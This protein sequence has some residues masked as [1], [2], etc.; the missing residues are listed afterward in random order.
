MRTISKLVLIDCSDV[1][2]S[3]MKSFANSRGLD[4]VCYTSVSE[5][6]SISRFADFDV[7]IVENDKGTLSGTEVGEYLSAPLSD[8]PL[9]IISNGFRPSLAARGAWPKSIQDF[10]HKNDGP[11]AILDSA[12]EAC[13]RVS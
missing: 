13:K 5:M 11:D 10:V 12:L 9:I 3:L 7:A 2:R 4:L 6:G 8:M 1:D